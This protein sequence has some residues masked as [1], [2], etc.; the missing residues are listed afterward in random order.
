ML[1]KN[2]QAIQTKNFT[3]GIWGS[4]NSGYGYGYMDIV[5]IVVIAIVGKKLKLKLKLKLK[6]KKKTFSLHRNSKLIHTIYI[7]QKSTKTS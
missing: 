7:T 4:G 6:K 1:P 3:C 2:E 5:N